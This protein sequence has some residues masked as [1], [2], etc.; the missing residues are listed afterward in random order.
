M[1][2]EVG[3]NVKIRR[4]VAWVDENDYD[5]DYGLVD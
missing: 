3:D 4:E 1:N 5:W 2:F